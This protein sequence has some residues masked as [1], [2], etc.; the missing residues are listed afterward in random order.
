MADDITNA[1]IWANAAVY[2]ATDL[3]APLPATPSTPFSAA[4][5]LVGLLDGGDGF[6]TNWEE[7]KKDHFAWGGALVRTTRKNGK[8]TKKFTALENNVTTR[9][10]IWPG[11]SA[12]QIVKPIPAKVKLAFETTEGGKVERYVTRNYAEVAVD[13]GI[14][15]NEDD[16]T[17]Y[18]LVATIFPDTSALP[19][20][21]DR[22]AAPTI[23]SIAISPLTLALALA[24]AAIKTLV[25]TA[26]Y[27]DAST[28]NI[29]AQAAWSTSAPTKATVSAGYVTAVAA[30]TANITCAYGGV[31]STAP[32]VVTV[33]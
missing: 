12:S 33:T 31:T 13:G 30:G 5:T 28:G 32:C 3:A 29:T 7:E 27:S 6:E 14:K 20:Y 2:V 8:M 18:G 23:T 26:T 19:V 25:A 4:W 21:F 15:D 17:K 24:G 9:S 11:S 22:Q 16:L 10:L 1:S